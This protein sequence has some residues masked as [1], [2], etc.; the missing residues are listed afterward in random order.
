M[1]TKSIAFFAQ[2]TTPASGPSPAVNY[3]RLLQS[4]GR[5]LLLS[6]LLAYFAT[7]LMAT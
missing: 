2:A 4:L 3:R 7:T 1:K 5:L 6:L